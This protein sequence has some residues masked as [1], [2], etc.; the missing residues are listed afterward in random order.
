MEI[1]NHNS[2]HNLLK[3]ILNIIAVLNIKNNVN[4]IIKY[5]STETSKILNADRTTIYIYEKE[6]NI[7]WSLFAE[8]LENEKIVN[9]EVGKGMAGYVAKTGETLITNDAYNEPFFDAS[10]DKRFNY[11]TRNLICMP[12]K[13][14]KGEL[15]GVIQVINK[16]DNLLFDKND[17]ELLSIIAVIGA[18]VLDRIIIEKEIEKREKLS[19]IGNI[20]SGVIHDI[21]NPLSVIIGFSDIIKKMISDEKAKEYID[22]ILTE[23]F[24]IQILLNEILDFAKD[25][26]IMN[27]I[28]LNIDDF[29]NSLKYDINNLTKN[30]N[31][32]II[33]ELNTKS[34][35]LLDKDRFYRVIINIVKNSVEAL[36]NAYNIKDKK[37]IIKTYEKEDNVILEITD[38]GPGINPKIKDNL[39]EPFVTIDKPSGTGLGLSIVKKIV[40]HHQAKIEVISEQNKGS[41]FQIIFQ[42]K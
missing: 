18:T 23:C 30:T 12:M 9:L 38:N 39:F 14:L 40:D 5:L 16:K 28:E 7:I 10:F 22:I 31:I 8:G 29:I 20:T 41:T 21:K 35:I 3:S 15:V 2:N 19:L 32:K 34:T 36:L 27:F 17:E 24:K 25:K 11:K 26:Y 37:I 1:T 13:N 33:K 4:D 6:K 42:K